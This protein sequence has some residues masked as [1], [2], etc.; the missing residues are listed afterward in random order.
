MRLAWGRESVVRQWGPETRLGYQGSTLPWRVSGKSNVG[1]E[2]V[3][4]LPGLGLGL[5]NARDP[6][7]E[8]KPE[9][10]EAQP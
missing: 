6:S 9:A 7:V 4:W 1:L 8:K 3:N 10:G 5:E 2:G